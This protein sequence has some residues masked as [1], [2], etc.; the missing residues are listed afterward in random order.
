MRH[1]ILKHPRVTSG[2]RDD[3]IDFADV[4]TLLCCKGDRL[5]GGGD[6]HASQQLIDHLERRAL[7]RFVAEF[8]ELRRHRI[9]RGSR[10][11]K[12]RLAAGGENSQF[13]L[14]GTLRA[15]ADRR[16][17]I[18]PPGG[19]KLFCQTAGDI[20]VHGR[21][22][23]ENRIL[24]QGFGDAVLSEQDRLGLRCIDHDA[25][26]GVGVPGDLRRCRR[27]PPA[28]G[29]PFGDGL[30]R[31][32]ASRDIESGTLQ[33]NRHAE[34]HRTEADNSNTSHGHM[35]SQF[36]ACPHIWRRAVD[37]LVAWLV[38]RPKWRLSHARNRG[39]SDRKRMAE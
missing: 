20:G 27:A 24:R 5:A 28:L 37:C 12:C 8:V 13:A 23:N 4:E 14:R 15:T 31:D 19:L 34:A 1:A 38:A 3:L 22:R 21:R 32:I 35:I 7:P 26:D 18:M 17:E 11:E 2:C 25:D 33:R 39:K 29:H 36:V 9:E 30:R 10:F 16:I 6:M